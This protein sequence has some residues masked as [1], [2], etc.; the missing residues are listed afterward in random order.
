MSATVLAL[1]DRVQFTGTV[2]KSAR[3]WGGVRYEDAPVPGF[4][5][6]KKG[7]TKTPAGYSTWEPTFTPHAE[8]VVVG[9]RRYT[10]MENDEGIWVP[11]GV[12]EF[13][14]YLIA[15]HLSRKPVIVRLDQIATINTEEP[16][17]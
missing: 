7:A 8:G 15:Y 9:K 2:V 17:A 3:N 6:Y 4:E 1:G 12:Q 13:T 10:S 14:A 5:G 11:D 16:A